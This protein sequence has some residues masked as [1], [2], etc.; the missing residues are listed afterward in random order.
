MNIYSS[1]SCLGSPLYVNW[2]WQSPVR[3]KRRE[4]VQRPKRYKCPGSESALAEGGSEIDR[5][6]E[7][8]MMLKEPK[9][10]SDLHRDITDNIPAPHFGTYVGTDKQNIF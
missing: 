4:F 5:H 6:C 2:F 7:E 9:L 10:S 8:S 1:C 3:S